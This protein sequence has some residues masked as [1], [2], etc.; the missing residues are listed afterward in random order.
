MSWFSRGTDERP[1]K[2]DPRII[3]AP[4]MPKGYKEVNAIIKLALEFHNRGVKESEKELLQ[5]SINILTKMK[6]SK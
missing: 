5:A 6:D 1:R 2:P 4:S 3:L